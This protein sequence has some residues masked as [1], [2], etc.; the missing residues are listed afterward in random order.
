MSGRTAGVTLARR[1]KAGRAL[2]GIALA[3]MAVA[4]CATA[5]APGPVEIV[6]HYSAFGPAEVHVPRGVPVTFVLANEDP[7]DHEWLI[8]DEAFHERHRNGTEPAHGDR[9]TEVSL[10]ALSTA[11]TTLTFEVPGDLAFICHFPGHEAYGMVGVV[12]VD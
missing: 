10:P 11:E 9:P 8:G 3:A 6:I 5:A 4:G 2:A 1:A 12:H 7:I